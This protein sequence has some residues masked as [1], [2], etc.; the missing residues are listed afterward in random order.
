MACRALTAL[1]QADNTIVKTW[2]TPREDDGLKNHVELVQLLDIADLEAGTQV[3]GQP[4]TAPTCLPQNQLS[5]PV[6]M[7]INQAHNST[8]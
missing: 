1:F 8:C 5:V 6:V 4:L 3:A 2:G 7:V